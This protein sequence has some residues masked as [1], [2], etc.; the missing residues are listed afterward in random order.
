MTFASSHHRGQAEVPF[1]GAKRQ[2]LVRAQWAVTRGP[3]EDSVG[4]S[5]CGLL[6][7]EPVSHMAPELGMNWGC[8]C[9]PADSRSS[10]HG[11]D[12]ACHCVNSC[13]STA[14]RK[15]PVFWSVSGGDTTTHQ[16]NDSAGVLAFFLSFS[17][18]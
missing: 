6:M 3:Q 7:N 4:L 14:R 13:P 1:P 11:A 9:V 5:S 2:K 10:R 15:Q 8:G 16:E 18:Y 17:P 12:V